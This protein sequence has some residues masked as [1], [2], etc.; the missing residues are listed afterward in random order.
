MGA[1]NRD[2]GVERMSTRHGTWG[3]L[4]GGDRKS[5]PGDALA[6]YKCNVECHSA[7]FSVSSASGTQAKLCRQAVHC[8]MILHLQN[9]L[10]YKSPL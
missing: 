1:A 7:N 2:E 9:V 8:L 3:V 6:R 4:S 10:P 5:G